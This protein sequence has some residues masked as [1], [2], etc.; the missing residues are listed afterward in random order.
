MRECSVV[1]K[2]EPTTFCRR[3]RRDDQVVCK[4]HWFRLPKPLRDEVWRLYR[5]A[6]GSAEHRAVIRECL[7]FLNAPL[8]AHANGTVS[9]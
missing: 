1:I 8:E 3:M 6:R 9:G 2:R 4:D 7:R 5:S